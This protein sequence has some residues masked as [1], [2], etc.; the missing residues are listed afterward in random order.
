MMVPPQQPSRRKVGTKLRLLYCSEFNTKAI[1]KVASERN[2][3]QIV[4]KR[5]Q[6][7]QHRFLECLLSR[8]DY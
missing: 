7:V 2:A 3:Q 8:I 4:L 6:V 5:H 1:D